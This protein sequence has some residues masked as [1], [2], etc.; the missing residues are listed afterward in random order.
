M[1][2]DDVVI[3]G[4]ISGLRQLFLN[5]Q[6]AGRID[7]SGPLQRR[8]LRLSAYAAAFEGQKEIVICLCKENGI[9]ACHVPDDEDTKTLLPLTISLLSERLW[10]DMKTSHLNCWPYL[11]LPGSANAMPLANKETYPV[12]HAAAR[13]GVLHAAA[14]H[15]V[16]QVVKKLVLKHGMDIEQYIGQTFTPLDLAAMEHI[17][18]SRRGRQRTN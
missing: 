8:A 4:D 6:K 9:P 7:P 16:L 11:C 3:T 18:K 2:L 13:H 14:P 12:L 17:K 5:Y 15:G 1:E 10:V